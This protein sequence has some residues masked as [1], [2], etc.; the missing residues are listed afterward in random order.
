M[1]DTLISGLQIVLTPSTFILIFAGTVVGVIFGAMPGVSASMAVALALPFAYPMNGVVA[2]AFLCSVYCASI[3]GGG[4]TA[5]LFKI[6]GTPSSAPT[7]FD[8]YPMAQRGEAGKALGYSLVASAIGGLIAAFAMAI[9]SGPLAAVALKFG[10]GEMFFVAIFGLTVVG[11]LSDNVIKGI[12]SGLFG[13]LLGTVGLSANGVSR[14]IMGILYLMDGIP[15]IPALLGL[16]ALPAIYELSG[17]KSAV[18]KVDTV[19]SGF[20]SLR[21][22]LQGFQDTLRRGVQA[23]L[24]AVLGTV[25]GII[26]AA[27]SAIAGDPCLCCYRRLRRELPPVR[28]LP[29]GGIQCAELSN[30]AERFP[31]HAPDPGPPAGRDG[32]CGTAA[33]QPAVRQLLGDFQEPYCAGAGGRQPGLC[34]A[35]LLYEGGEA[36]K[37]CEITCPALFSKGAGEPS[38]EKE[39]ML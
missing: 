4:I 8:G 19:S 1:L 3:T 33:H 10:P 7:T 5:I 21:G 6:P 20:A 23:L 17:R 24:Y 29:A 35:P 25:V 2:I 18:L 16:L 28:L 14:V 36:Q 38:S 34:P 31:R 26:P 11:S 9:V 27:G 32:G 37:T 22:L 12:F 30:E 15:T 39:I 13:I